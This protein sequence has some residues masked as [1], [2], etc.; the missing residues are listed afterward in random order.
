M[1]VA[2][3]L[4][5]TPL[6]CQ[7]TPCTPA[8]DDI[9][10][11]AVVGAGICGACL[12]YEAS[13]TTLKTVV[14][15]RAVEVGMGTS[16]AMSGIIH[17]GIHTAQG[18]LKA[19]FEQLGRERVVQLCKD[20]CVSVKQCGELV[21][22][23]GET[24]EACLDEAARVCEDL[25]LEYHFWDAETVAREEPHLVG[26]TRALKVPFTCVTNPF[27]LVHAL[28][29]CA[30][31]NGVTLSC[32]TEVIGVNRVA[33]LYEI[34]VRYGTKT[35]VTTGYVYARTLV[36]AAGVQADT[37]TDL[38]RPVVAK[39]E[40]VKIIKRR[41]QIFVLDKNLDGVTKHVI[42]T[43]RAPVGT[44]GEIVS[45][46]VLI[47]PTVD[48]TVLVG[49]TAEDVEEESLE[50]VRESVPAVFT[51]IRELCPKITPGA[52]IC[53]FAGIRAVSSTGDFVLDSQ[54]GFFQCAGI[55]SP[56]F[57]AA[58]ALA[59]HLLDEVRR[60]LQEAG[61]TVGDNSAW[62]LRRLTTRLARVAPDKR[63]RFIAED[64]A[65][66][67][68]LCGCEMVTAGDVENAITEG[69]RSLPGLKLR[70]RATAGRCQGGF[71]AEGLREFLAGRLGITPDSVAHLDPVRPLTI[72]PYPPESSEVR[73]YRPTQLTPQAVCLALLDNIIARSAYLRRRC[74]ESFTFA[75]PFVGTTTV[76]PPPAVP[77]DLVIIGSGPAGVGAALAAI[78]ANP[79]SRVLIVTKDAHIGGILPVC[80][81]SGYGLLRY[82]EELTGPEFAEM[83]EEELL[84]TDVCILA[85]SFVYTT[86]HSKADGTFTVSALMRNVGQLHIRTRAV[87]TAQGCR[88]RHRYNMSI[89]GTRAYGVMTAGAAQKLINVQGRMP[90]KR[91]VV[92]GSGDIGLIM[93]RRFTLEGGQ[94]VGVFEQGGLPSGLPRNTQACLIDFDIP[95]FLNETVVRVHGDDAVTSVDVAKVDPVTFEPRMDTVRN[96]ECD[97]VLLAGGLLQQMALTVQLGCRGVNPSYRGPIV[98]SCRSAATDKLLYT[99]G[100]GLQVHDL[101]DEAVV[102][103]EIAGFAAICQLG[104]ATEAVTKYPPIPLVSE[105][106]LFQYILPASVSPPLMTR[107]KLLERALAGDHS[108]ECSIS[109]RVKRP[110]HNKVLRL[111]ARRA[112]T[113]DVVA[114]LVCQEIDELLPAEMGICRIPV[115]DLIDR[116]YNHCCR[117]R[118]ELVLTIEDAPSRPDGAAAGLENLEVHQM[119]CLGCPNSCNMRVYT[120]NGRFV[121][122]EGYTCRV[123][124]AFGRGEIENPTR[125]FSTTIPVLGGE[126]A[127]VPIKTL[128]PMPR[129]QILEA[130]A[131]IRDSRP[132]EAPVRRG[133]VLFQI[134]GVRFV[135]CA[136]VARASTKAM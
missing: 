31:E 113:C 20:L 91:A 70:T 118:L 83:L 6:R 103:G 85:N 88:E 46:G 50:T 122:A 72:G 28:V 24:E 111:Y 1:Y 86:A 110:I 13:R 97:C 129:R 74:A 80:I 101:A 18:T 63:A 33:G 121:R 42:F 108:A 134:G 47:V 12:A 132:V 102:E 15:E 79:A 130:M 60:Y 89:F 5:K 64:V 4:P 94:V 133:T 119:R 77:Y 135:T 76:P 51:H 55:Q 35:I 84:Q 21:V 69:C 26:I 120:Q 65:F 75:Q 117:G 95:L 14:L 49:P 105:G 114:E 9:Y 128:T 67:K 36:N 127:R 131:L 30:V 52:T 57:T 124:L 136:S 37:I 112:G 106:D 44:S 25:G 92:V 96:V 8:D 107:A 45:K 99:A 48:G 78:R 116:V 61:I 19:R 10:D 126:A 7:P 39:L 93:A 115:V 71:C 54:D 53:T 62:K 109:F 104:L 40:R 90:G 38:A 22:A 32:S 68:V 43:A 2:H 87:L 17:S 59:L 16:R 56:G 58:P 34:E 82:G 66:S 29:N 125:S 100:N 11:V 3:P 27:E 23:R 41:G 73:L 98:D 123:G 81:H